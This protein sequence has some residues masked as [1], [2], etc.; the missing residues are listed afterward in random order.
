WIYPSVVLRG[1]N[2]I[3]EVSSVAL[4]RHALQADSGT[5]MI[6]LGK[7]TKS[8]IISKGIYSCKAS[9]A[10]RLLVRISTN[11]ANARNI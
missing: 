9:Q 5:K 3:G 1:D 2:S 4:T 7:N 11:A 8:T 6:Q 10:Y